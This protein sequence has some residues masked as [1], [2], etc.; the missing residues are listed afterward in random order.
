MSQGVDLPVGQV[1]EVAVAVDLAAVVVDL[2]AS[3]AAA[4]EEEVRVVAGKICYL[5]EEP[6]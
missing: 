6:S 1:V 4:E 5:K 3:A 2:G